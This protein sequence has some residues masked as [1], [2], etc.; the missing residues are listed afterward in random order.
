MNG[1]LKTRLAIR[2]LV[3]LSNN[4]TLFAHGVSEDTNKVCTILLE[5][6]VLFVK[7]L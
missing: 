7:I 6:A 5:S 4:H 3:S 2:M 1:C